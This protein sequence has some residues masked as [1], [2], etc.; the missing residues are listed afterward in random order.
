MDRI[1]LVD[2]ADI[3]LR[4]GRYVAPGGMAVNPVVPRGFREIDAVRIELGG[5]LQV[6]APIGLIPAFGSLSG[7]VE[8]ARQRGNLPVAYIEVDITDPL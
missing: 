3:R 8:R 1:M 7:H 5:Y 6:L 4:V 2:C